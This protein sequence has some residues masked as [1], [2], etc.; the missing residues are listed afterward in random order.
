MLR[1][2][3]LLRQP[4][5]APPWCPG[6]SSSPVPHRVLGCT[7]FIAAAYFFLWFLPPFTN[8]RG[9]WYMT[10]YCLFQA[11]ST[12]LQV[13]YTALTMLLT[14]RPAERDSA[15]AYR[16][17]GGRGGGGPRARAGPLSARVSQA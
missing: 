14:P 7:P 10:F 5:G 3:S 17:C 6:C 4:F 11:L 16:E 12:F 15:T 13:P 1:A 9:L 2:V 8:L